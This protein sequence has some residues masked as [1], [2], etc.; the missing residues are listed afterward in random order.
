MLK[1]RVRSDTRKRKPR[2]HSL[3]NVDEQL[4]D[5]PHASLTHALAVSA[6]QESWRAHGRPRVFAVGPHAPQHSLGDRSGVWVLLVLLR[7]PLLEPSR[8]RAAD[9][10]QSLQCGGRSACCRRVFLL[11]CQGEEQEQ[12]RED[13][14]RRRWMMG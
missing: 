6:A 5:S 2:E 9:E 10:L 4:H 1:E 3:L 11:R 7:S 14:M 8:W 13:A 12:E